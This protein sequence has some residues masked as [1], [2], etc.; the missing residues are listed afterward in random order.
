VLELIQQRRARPQEYAALVRR[1]MDHLE[2]MPRKQRTRW[3]QLLSYIRALIYHDREPSEQQDLGEEIL[4]SA[5]TDEHRREVMTMA[6]SM[7]EFLRAE[8]HK[9][10]HKEGTVEALRQ[11]LVDQIRLRFGKIP[12]ATERKIAATDDQVHLQSWLSRF[13]TATSLADIGIGQ[14]DA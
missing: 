13:A 10:G 4:A 1:V 6:Q 8:G 11:T 12:K 9:E 7:A 3:L 5:R 14:E 2:K